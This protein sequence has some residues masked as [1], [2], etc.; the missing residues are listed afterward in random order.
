MI[1]PN[2]E[3][4]YNLKTE[5]DNQLDT[6]SIDSQEGLKNFLE[7][8]GV[9][10]DEYMTVLNDFEN[11]EPTAEDKLRES[12]FYVIPDPVRT[13]GSA[14]GET[15]SYLGTIGGQGIE[16]LAGKEKRK[17]VEGGL[18]KAAEVVEEYTPKPVSY[19]FKETFDPKVTLTEEIV[20][21]LL[22]F[23]TAVGA[24]KQVT[25]NIVKPK[26]KLGKAAEVFGIGVAADVL[27]RDED[28]QIT[29]ELISLIPGMESVVEDLVINPDDSV[30]EK[31]L[32]QLIDSAAGAGIIGAGFAT[33]APIV[34]SGGKK[35]LNKYK[36]VTKDKV[37]TP[38]KPL[39]E[40]K[41]VESAVEDIGNGIYRQ[42]NKII[43][44]IGK[45]NTG[46]G[47]VF[48][49]NLSIP[50][51][52]YE[53]ILKKNSFVKA[54]EIISRSELKKLES[55]QKK[56]GGDWQV[57]NKV[58][59]GTASQGDIQSLNPEII[60]QLDTMRNMLDDKTQ[61]ALDLLELPMDNELSIQLDKGMGA[62]LTRTFE[63]FSN[64]SWSKKIMS[65]VDNKIDITD[66]NNTEVIKIVNN[67]RRHFKKMYP[68]YTE[69][70]IDGIIDTVIS[71]AKNKDQMSSIIDMISGSGYGGPAA[72]IL[73][74]R[75]DLDKPILELLGEVKDVKRNFIETL[76]NQN[77]LI[78][79]A[80]YLQDIKKFAEQNLNKEVKLDGLIPF[81]PTDV[82]TFLNKAEPGV[83]SNLGKISQ[84]ELGELGK[85]ADPVG[86]NK[87]TTTDQLST[88]LEKGV[89][90]FELDSNSALGRIYNAT[91]AKPLA[92]TQATETIYDHTAYL[93]NTAGMFQQLA[94]NGYLFRPSGIKNA[95]NAAYNIIQR[96]KKDDPEAIN[97]IRILLEESVLDSD[98]AVENIKKNIDRFGEDIE[99]T[100][101]KAAKRGI[102]APGQVYG[103]IDDF[104][105]I[106]ATFAEVEDYR[107]VFPNLTE[108][109]LLRK[110]AKNVRNTMPSYTTG[111]FYAR[112]LGRVPLGTYAMYPAEI[113]R[114]SANILKIGVSDLWEGFKTG[115][116]ALA[117]KG[118][119]RLASAG[120]VI[121]GIA[122]Y[123]TR[124]N[125]AMGITKEDER[126]INIVSPEW[127]QNS[128]KIFTQ[129]LYLDPKTNDVMTKFTDT[130]TI[131][132]HEFLKTP[133]RAIIG[134]VM[135]GKE[136]TDREID[137]AVWSGFKS[138]MSPFVSEKFLTSAVL[139]ASRG[140]DDNG[141]P[142][143][144]VET[145]GDNFWGRIVYAVPEIAKPGSLKGLNKLEEAENSEAV[146]GKDEGVSYGG[147]P[148][149]AKEQEFFLKTGIRN[150]T[151][152][153]SKS[154]GY[155]I[156]KDVQEINKT[157]QVFKDYLKKEVGIRPITPEIA[158]EIY[159]KYLS[160]QQQKRELQ[161]RLLDKINIIS[162]VQYYTKDSNEPK[163][164]G[165]E[166]ILKAVT[167]KGKY[168]VN[169]L[170][171]RTLAQ[172]KN[173]FFQPDSFSS[174][175]L[176]ELFKDKKLPLE[177][178][179]GLKE[180]EV[181][182][183]GSALKDIK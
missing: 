146:L 156:Y 9:G 145:L 173:G 92:Y 158:N 95:K 90:L 52:L 181:G 128:T 114:T 36:A 100:V 20:S 142:V 183:T 43:E 25:K 123:N 149:R 65:V 88:M 144:Y 152:N 170:I 135:A 59:D 140:V 84:K 8:Q 91:I 29:T 51:P 109:E 40:A 55:L 165:T 7:S 93:L 48:T 97:T 139:N 54:N 75:Q 179:K 82:A 22:Q 116:S 102:K 87:F 143:P 11:Q 117:Q 103:G 73:R 147:F 19:F 60:K 94:V 113:L 85:A 53:S 124:N 171:L 1:A 169:P 175:E 130:S 136:I 34:K 58:L 49:S 79:K 3:E 98:I 178:I 127:Q 27:I 61:L 157:K 99:N 96:V 16:L 62:Y 28:E 76:S 167:S 13:I 125:E 68:S 31:R 41:V 164:F 17:E 64:P 129:P 161:S 86:L 37:T 10:F 111:A 44:T 182:I 46:L 77:K 63:N 56:Y 50:K 101:L 131:D 148:N 2:T 119:N 70:Q 66:A 122:A 174:S 89:D 39:G 4:F 163:T 134:R 35:I 14:I 83:V 81:I 150:N 138:I 166:G 6:G 155:N 32:K 26:S 112:A 168:K 153:F 47:R 108:E 110:A 151:M 120:G 137:D 38:V 15:A 106:M 177:V 71:S 162:N 104:G 78:A 24:V 180:I 107:K 12:P 80:E 72:K 5:I 30:A 18:K 23:G 115:N 67:A 105:K 74:G 69:A 118:F 172:K 159:D 42:R 154:V 176:S 45:I 133:I 160:I 121:T 126:A 132:A 33:L 21:E 141:N 57:M